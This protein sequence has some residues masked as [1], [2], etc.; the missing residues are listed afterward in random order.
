MAASYFSHDANASD[1]PKILELRAQYPDFQGYAAY[2]VY[3]RL[4]EM[5]RVQSTYKLPTST[6]R[7]I[8]VRLG[9][10][11]A[12]LQPFVD[13][14][15]SI[16]LFETDGM[17]FW[18]ESLMRRMRKMDSV[19][20]AKKFAAKKGW[21]KRK[22]EEY[23]SNE[24]AKRMQSTRNENINRNINKNTDAISFGASSSAE[25]AERFDG[26]AL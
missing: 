22:D 19:R 9:L 25:L 11:G 17:W 1:D 14:C 18:S 7:G 26:E 2:G 10:D 12:W 4:V 8:A 3:W 21:E 5:L 24:R 13:F 16:H 23:I 20:D 6:I 15:I